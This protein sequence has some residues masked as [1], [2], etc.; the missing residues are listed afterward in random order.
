MTDFL[1]DKPQRGVDLFW[2]LRSMVEVR[3]GVNRMGKNC[4]SSGFWLRGKYPSKKFYKM[5]QYT[6]R[7]FGHYFKS[8]MADIDEGFRMFMN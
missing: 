5:E 6:S 8:M 3:F 1:K 4:I 7:N 2:Y